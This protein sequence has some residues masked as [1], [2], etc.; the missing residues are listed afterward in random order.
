MMRGMLAVIVATILTA[1][2]WGV[3]GPVLLNGQLAMQ[4]S[5]LRPFIGVGIAYFIIAVAAPVVLLRLRGEKGSW[6]SS[7]LAWSLFAGALGALGAL[8]IILAFSFKGKPLFVMPLVFGLAPVVN[9]FVTMF[10]ARTLRQ[11]GPL[12]LAGLILVVIGAVTVL[13][14]KPSHQAAKVT[15]D[16]DSGAITVEREVVKEGEKHAEK[17][18]APDEA[19]LEKTDA[20]AFKAYNAFK[21]SK[22]T[23]TDFIAATLFI[24]LTAICWGAYGPALHKGQ[25]A[26]LGSRLRPLICV[27]LAYFLIGVLVPLPLLSSLEPNASFNLTGMLWSLGGGAAGALGALGII[28]AFTYGGKPVYVMPL[29][30]G[31]APVV[32]AFTE[33]IGKSMYN[34]IGP[35]FYAGLIIVVVGAV[36]VLVFAPKGAPHAPAAAPAPNPL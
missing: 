16:K 12:F 9:A 24:V 17:V 33:I 8:G 30:F 34:D 11:A 6:T 14:A 35:L 27:G 25:V 31:C 1:I 28:M 7:G 22:M 19:T 23:W 15:V 32:N 18:S 21:N 3:Y 36:V 5:R 29:V 13:A 26:M 2:C 10:L 4:N 20:D